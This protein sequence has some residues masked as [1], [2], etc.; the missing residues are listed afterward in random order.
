[1]GLTLTATLVGCGDDEGGSAVDTGEQVSLVGRWEGRWDGETGVP[2]CSEDTLV[3]AITSEEDGSF[4]AQVDAGCGG[5]FPATGTVNGLALD[6][7]GSAALGTITYTGELRDGGRRMEGEWSVSGT[8][9]QGT[10]ELEK[11][12]DEPGTIAG[13]EPSPTAPAEGEERTP[14]S[15]QPSAGEGGVPEFDVPSGSELV[16]RSTVQAPALPVPVPLPGA[17]QEAE[18]AEYTSPLSADEVMAF[19]EDEFGDWT[20]SFSFDS[21]AEKVAAYQR[22]GDGGWE[23]VVIVAQDED[24]GSRFWTYAGTVQQP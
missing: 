2:N 16:S 7:E 1:M 12:S 23:V 15:Q 5:Q 24:E 9:F 17:M 10:W 20:E 13:T 19:F 21:P 3:L 22:Q 11:V 18:V 14:T 8:D 4:T 6:V